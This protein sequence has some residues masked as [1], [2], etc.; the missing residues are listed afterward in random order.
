VIFYTLNCIV[1]H[2]TYSKLV[3]MGRTCYVVGC[4]SGYKSTHEANLHFFRPKTKKVLLTW[5]KI[6]PRKDLQLQMK[7]SVCHK[8]FMEE[9]II[10]E[11]KW[12]G[13]DGPIVYPLKI[14][15]LVDGAIPKLLLGE[16]FK[17]YYINR[18]P[19]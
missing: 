3:R 10:K 12:T 13:K 2:L 7:H 4:K 5:R 19:N 11:N 15:K 8:H 16:C 14:W 1:L 17:A 9:D 6:I 18:I